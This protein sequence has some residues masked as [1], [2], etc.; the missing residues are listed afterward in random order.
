MA[1]L[2]YVDR[3]GEIRAA[4]PPTILRQCN[5]SV[6]AALEWLNIISAAAKSVATEEEEAPKPATA[7]VVENQ[8]S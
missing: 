7:V 2:E 3:A 1:V 6:E 8:S 4:R 5:G